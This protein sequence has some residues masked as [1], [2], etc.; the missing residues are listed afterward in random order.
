MNETI[1][2]SRV[3]FKLKLVDDLEVLSDNNKKYLKIIIARGLE[4]PYHKVW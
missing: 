1:E 4:K 2:N 3:E